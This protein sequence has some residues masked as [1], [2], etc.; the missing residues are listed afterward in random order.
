MFFLLE[1]KGF[2]CELYNAGQVKALPGRPETDRADSIWLAKITER[3]M[4]ASSFVPPSRSAGCGP[5][6]GT[7]ATSP[8]PAPPRSKG[9]RNCWKTGT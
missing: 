5:A 1:S 2:D 6:P 7:A 4:I 8:R 3:G 9:S